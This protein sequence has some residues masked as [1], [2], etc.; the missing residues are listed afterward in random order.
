MHL[1]GK[2]SSGCSLCPVPS[3]QHPRRIALPYL[4]AYLC[5]PYVRHRSLLVAS[6][7][8]LREQKGFGKLSGCLDAWEATSILMKP[9]LKSCSICGVGKVGPYDGNHT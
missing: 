9:A 8:V 3:G 7:P 5:G 1:H 2:R 4:H 6:H